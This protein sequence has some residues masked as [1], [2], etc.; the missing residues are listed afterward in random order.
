M[1]VVSLEN[2][3]VK[4]QRCLISDERGWFLKV[5][6][7]KENCLPPHT[8]EVYFI[9]GIKGKLRGSHYHLLAQEWF[10]VIVG[11]AVLKLEDINTHERL[12][13]IMD[14]QNPL[15]VY[16][17]RGVAHSLECT[18]DCNQFILCAYTDT[19]YDPTDTIQ[20]EINCRI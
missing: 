5:I 14:A 11:K 17:P 3:V 18:D 8:G 1:K 15:T 12:D 9:N 2:R 10:T 7:G 4:Y 20:Y 19:L 6:T 13:I 16:V